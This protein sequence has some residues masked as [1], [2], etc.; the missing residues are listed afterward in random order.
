MSA[1]IGV[2]AS[3][4]DRT[5]GN[6]T[7]YWT[8][9]KLDGKRYGGNKPVLILASPGTASAGEDFAY[10]MQALNRA[11]VISEPI[12]GGAHP[13]PLSRWRAFLCSH[14]WRAQ[15]QSHYRHQLGRRGRRPRYRGAGQCTGHIQE[16][17]AASASRKRPVCRHDTLTPTPFNCTLRWTPTAF[18]SLRK[19]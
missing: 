19:L 1:K 7:Q 12:W 4:W 8:Q 9:D 15:H 14:T 2:F 13:A 17:D 18:S 3:I 16:A 5:T 6:T 11:T 10:T